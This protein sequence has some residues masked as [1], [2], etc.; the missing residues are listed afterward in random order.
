MRVNKIEK[1]ESLKT[2]L[3]DCLGEIVAMAMR[4]DEDSIIPMMAAVEEIDLAVKE[5]KK[6]VAEVR[7]I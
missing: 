1:L 7:K 5:A 3:Q 4:G 2:R 6:I